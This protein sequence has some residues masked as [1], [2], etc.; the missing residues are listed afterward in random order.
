MIAAGRV[1]LGV[2]ALALW[3]AGHWA[4]GAEWISGPVEVVLGD[5]PWSAA[6]TPFTL[7]VEADPDAYGFHQVGY[8]AAVPDPQVDDLVAIRAQH[9]RAGYESELIVG[10]ERCREYLSW[11]WSDWDAPVE[12]RARFGRATL[13]LAAH[14]SDRA[15]KQSDGS[16]NHVIDHLPRL[17]LRRR[18]PPPPGGGAGG[19]ARRR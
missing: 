10:A 6:A 9:E 2:A 15:R 5:G 14:A 11:T 17:L 4:V 7:R 13:P 19:R 16:A 18:G 3:Q 1:A 8:L 12:A